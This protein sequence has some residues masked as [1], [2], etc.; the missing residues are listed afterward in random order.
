MVTADS[1]AKP[2]TTAKPAATSRRALGWLFVFFA[3]SALGMF[4]LTAWSYQDEHGGTAG[5]ATVLECEDGGSIQRSVDD[6]YCTGRWTVDGRERTGDVY[7]AQPEDVGKTLSVRIHDDHASRP[8]IGITIAAV[9]FTLLMAGVAVMMLVQWWR[10]PR[11]P[12][13]ENGP[14]EDGPLESPA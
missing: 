1:T 5:E 3:I 8:Q 12:P 14:P 10:A 6:V 4:A 2:D 13:N 7:N 9:V 11:V